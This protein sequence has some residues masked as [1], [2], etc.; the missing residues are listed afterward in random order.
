MQG[1]HAVYR[2]PFS[3]GR[4]RIGEG[5]GSM[6]SGAK[7]GKLLFLRRFYGSTEWLEL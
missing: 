6:W 3:G 2:D 4:P 5:Y 7:Q 1:T